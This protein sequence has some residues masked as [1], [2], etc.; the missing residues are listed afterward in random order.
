MWGILNDVCPFGQMM[1]ALPDD[2][3]CGNDVVPLA[4]LANI[5]SLATIGSNIIMSEANN[6][7][8][9]QAN[10]SY[11]LYSKNKEVRVSTDFFIF[12]I[13]P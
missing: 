1:S 10:T 8:F 5:T 11:I 9:A 3:A 12:L 2:V 7:I 13:M 4:Q 6:I